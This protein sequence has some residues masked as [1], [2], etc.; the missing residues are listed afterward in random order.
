[1]Q[2]VASHASHAVRR[3]KKS[4]GSCFRAKGCWDCG[5]PPTFDSLTCNTD[6][7]WVT[8]SESKIANDN[9]SYEGTE[10]VGMR[11]IFLNVLSMECANTS[12]E[13]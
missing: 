8:K 12:N 13:Q 3:G 10:C 9:N 6:C 11:E 1:M 2:L 7:T 4:P 5:I